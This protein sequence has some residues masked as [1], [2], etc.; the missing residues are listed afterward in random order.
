MRKLT[1]VLKLHVLMPPATATHA[2]GLFIGPGS[3]C[4]WEPFPLSTVNALEG[5]KVFVAFSQRYHQPFKRIVLI[6]K[7]IDHVKS[8]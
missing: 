2:L 7:N 1:E 3:S 8:T 4:L 5:Y 6:L